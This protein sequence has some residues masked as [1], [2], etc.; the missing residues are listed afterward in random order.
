MTTKTTKKRRPPV[1]YRPPVAL[2]AEFYERVKK[3][4][5]SVS[6]YLTECWYGRPAPRQVRTPP[7]EQKMLARLLAE[8]GRIRDT[9]EAGIGDETTLPNDERMRLEQVRDELRLLS[10]SLRKAMGRAP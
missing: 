7:L 6:G 5:K 3:S 10:A 1:S 2:E 9:V 8:A 4:G